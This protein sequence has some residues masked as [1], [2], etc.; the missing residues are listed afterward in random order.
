MLYTVTSLSWRTKLASY[1]SC[2]FF[3]HPASRK[4][5]RKG[6]PSSFAHT[7][8]A[9]DAAATNLLDWTRSTPSS[10]PQVAY[11]E[12]EMDGCCCHPTGWGLSTPTIAQ[13]D[14]MRWDGDGVLLLLPCYAAGMHELSQTE[15]VF[16]IDLFRFS[17]DLTRFFPRKHWIHFLANKM[18]CG[19]IF[20]ISLYITAFSILT[21]N[22]FT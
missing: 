18:H 4:G 8:R 12:L 11:A 5:L 17:L 7:T 16:P 15:Y 14:C 2:N 19:R 20:K 13:P 9:L 21:L 3:I 22:Q 6:R 1:L 10:R